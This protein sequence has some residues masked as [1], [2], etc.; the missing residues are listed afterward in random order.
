MILKAELAAA[1][2]VIWLI[3]YHNNIRLSKI[4]PK[5]F[6][7]GQWLADDQAILWNDPG[8]VTISLPD[9]RDLFRVFPQYKSDTEDEDK[10]NNHGKGDVE[11]EDEDEVEVE[12]KDKNENENENEDGGHISKHVREDDSDLRAIARI[13]KASSSHLC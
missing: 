1:Q 3:L 8:T 13:F 12:D 9:L 2:T 11:D 5:A 7:K 4:K 10:E 6:N